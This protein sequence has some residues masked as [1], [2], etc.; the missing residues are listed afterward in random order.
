MLPAYTKGKDPRLLAWVE[1]GTPRLGT[2]ALMKGGNWD[3]KH[4]RDRH[5]PLNLSMGDDQPHRQDL[6]VSYTLSPVG[7]SSMKPA[8]F[9]FTEDV[10]FYIIP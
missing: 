10:H 1:A 4:I 2:S 6:K 5:C 3:R 7:S 9:V 8:N